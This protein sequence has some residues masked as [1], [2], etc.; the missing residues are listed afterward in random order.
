VAYPSK[1]LRYEALLKRFIRR[2]IANSSLCVLLLGMSATRVHNAT[3]QAS[4]NKQQRLPIIFRLLAQ[5][6]VLM[7]V[8]AYGWWGMWNVGSDSLAS[9]SNTL[10]AMEGP[11]YVAG[12]PVGDPLEEGSTRGGIDGS[13]DC[14]EEGFYHQMSSRQ[15]GVRLGGQ[16]HGA[17]RHSDDRVLPRTSE[18]QPSTSLGE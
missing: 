8:M 14:S 15:P 10:T 5:G 17:E 2:F 4:R 9:D 1:H 7:V 12:C 18:N 16:A 13:R 11:I 3:F 6:S